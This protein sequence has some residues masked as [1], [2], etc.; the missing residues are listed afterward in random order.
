MS[1]RRVADK[2]VPVSIGLPQSLLDRLNLQLDWRQ[3]RS[4]WVKNSIIA[5][6]EAHDSESQIIAELSSKRIITL[7]FNRNIINWFEYEQL[8]SKIPVE[9]I[10]E[11]Q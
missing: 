11:A 9:G 6:L 4:R 10:E 5:K 1:R 3:S 2:T 8:I 7:L